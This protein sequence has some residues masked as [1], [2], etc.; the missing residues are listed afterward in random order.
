MIGRKQGRATL[1]YQVLFFGTDL[2]QTSFKPHL[3]Y[4]VVGGVEC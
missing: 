1:K 2:G 4:S 3:V